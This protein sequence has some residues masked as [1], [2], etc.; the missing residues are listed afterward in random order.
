MRVAGRSPGSVYCPTA[1]HA[2]LAPHDTPY[3][4]FSPVLLGSGVAGMLQ[5]VPSHTSAR[6]CGSPKFGG[7]LDAYCPTA[8]HEPADVQDTE[9]RELLWEFVGSSWPTA[10]QELTALHETALKLLLAGPGVD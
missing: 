10:S 2:S 9:A 5:A 7:V 8:V 1:V 3:R 6:V 4:M